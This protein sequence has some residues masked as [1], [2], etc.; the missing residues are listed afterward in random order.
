MFV[1]PGNHRYV[2]M[3]LSQVK[4]FDLKE[5]GA[6]NLRLDDRSGFKLGKFASEQRLGESM[7]IITL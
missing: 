7:V 5:I 6:I 1:F 2:L 4:E 3:A